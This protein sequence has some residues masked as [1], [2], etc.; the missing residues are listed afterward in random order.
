MKHKSAISIIAIIFVMQIAIFAQTTEVL[1]NQ[2]KES[3]EKADYVSAMNSLD[4]IFKR[5]PNNEAALTQRARIFVRQGKFTEASADVAK[6]LAQNPNNYEALNVRGVIKRERD[7]DLNG[8]LADFNRAVEIK[9]DYYLAVFNV[10]TANRRLHNVNEAITAFNKAIQLNPN[11]SLG[12]ANRGFLFL[13]TGKLN[14]AVLDNDALS[15]ANTD[16]KAF[17]ENM[18][19]QNPKNICAI[20]FLGEYKPLRNWNETYGFINFLNDGLNFFDGKNGAECAA[21]IAFRIGR[22]EANKQLEQANERNTTTSSNNSSPVIPNEIQKPFDQ[23]H[24]QIRNL[25]YKINK[26]IMDFNKFPY[27]NQGVAKR[28][29]VEQEIS[30][31][32]NEAADLIRKFLKDYDGKLPK[33]IIDHLNGDID[34]LLSG[35]E[36]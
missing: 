27:L 3:I 28:K 2:A 7:K 13:S 6:V 10:G 36:H 35:K 12:Y 15:E 23:L 16:R 29:K 30:D 4:I 24:N 17:W 32:R 21:A 5:S 19:A 22:E 33:A 20:R 11:D 8:A 31:I 25:E 34:K 18:L 26:K 14:E 1:I 9:P